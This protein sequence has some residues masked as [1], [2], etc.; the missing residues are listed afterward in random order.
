MPKCPECDAPV[1]HDARSCK[2][3]GL[4]EGEP[5][6]YAR[7]APARSDGAS[8][9]MVIGIG[10][11]IIVGVLILT[12][13]FTGGADCREC[14]G[15]KVVVCWNCKDGIA[16][17]ALCKGS[18]ADPQS[19]AKC[20]T[21]QGTGKVTPCPKCHGNPKKTCPTCGGKGTH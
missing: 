12:A 14:K 4:G 11:A 20:M 9:G 2:N 8:Y 1:A 21:C 17:C 19:F 15:K 3:C 16:K 10:A 5:P 13:L 6:P 18:G 7:I